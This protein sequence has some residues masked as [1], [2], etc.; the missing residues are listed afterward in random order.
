M[1]R[2]DTSVLTRSNQLASAQLK[3]DHPR[4]ERIQAWKDP[5]YPVP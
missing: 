3:N 1:D 2:T 4:N 5:G